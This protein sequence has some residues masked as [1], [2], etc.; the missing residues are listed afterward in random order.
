MRGPEGTQGG[1]S[2]A[3][4][5]PEATKASQVPGL[6]LVLNLFGSLLGKI[7]DGSPYAFKGLYGGLDWP[8][9]VYCR[10]GLSA[11]LA[12]PLQRQGGMRSQR[13]PALVLEPTGGRVLMISSNT[14]PCKPTGR[15]RPIPDSSGR[16]PAAESAPPEVHSQPASAIGDNKLP[17]HVSQ[18]P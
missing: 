9:H 2:R 7:W 4:G 6:L 10:D 5:K 14:W 8:S 3:A 16:C 12:L 11:T 1:G 17:H 13:P 15:G 18:I